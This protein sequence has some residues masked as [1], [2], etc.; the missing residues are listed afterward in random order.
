[1]FEVCKDPVFRVGPAVYCNASLLFI[2]IATLLILFLA[3]RTIGRLLLKSSK[4]NK[5]FWVRL[6]ETLKLPV[7]RSYCAYLSDSMLIN[8]V[9]FYFLMFIAIYSEGF[10][11]QL[12]W[13]V[14]EWNS[15][16]Q[17]ILAGFG[18][19]F[20]ASS[21]FVWFLVVEIIHNRQ[22]YVRMN[23]RK[24][25]TSVVE[26]NERR[27]SILLILKKSLIFAFPVLL[28]EEILT[29]WYREE[30]IETECSLFFAVR[31]IEFAFML[32]YIIPRLSFFG[33]ER[34]KLHKSKTLMRELHLNALLM[35]HLED[36]T[37]TPTSLESLVD[38]IIEAKM[39]CDWC[40]KSQEQICVHFMEQIITKRIELSF[41]R[42]KEQKNIA[43]GSAASMLMTNPRDGVAPLKLCLLGLFITGSLIC[44]SYFVS[45]FVIIPKEEDNNTGVICWIRAVCC[46]LN[47]FIIPTIYYIILNPELSFGK[48]HTVLETDELRDY[49]QKYDNMNANP[50][51]F[52][53][54]TAL[55]ESKYL[56]SSGSID[57][58]L[59]TDNDLSDPLLRI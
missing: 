55:F 25:I 32:C 50:N 46:T 11:R 28:G 29:Y 14:R 56:E 17:K 35:K 15:L 23:R 57:I 1:M 51:Q 10:M 27:S 20:R 9:A 24:L 4:E 45:V 26:V 6:W 41:D 44:A 49:Q 34:R 58:E 30:F 40:K 52:R 31:F 2:I 7:E 22:R 5:S 8:A 12:A 39:D 36:L 19:F 48:F 21:F 53:R 3:M 37:L 47:L 59:P 13:I 42:F 18:P 54:I 33:Y 43:E 38:Q 16:A